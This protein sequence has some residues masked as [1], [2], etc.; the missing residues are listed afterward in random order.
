MILGRPVNKR[1]RC[2]RQK[3]LL[4]RAAY[5]LILIL[6]VTFASACARR[7]ELPEQAQVA[8]DRGDYQTAA[9]KY[10]EFLKVNPHHDQVPTV[11][12]KVANIY[13]YHL[14]QYDRAIQQYIHLIE[15]YPNSAD[16][17]VSRQ[18]LAECYAALSKHREAINEYESLLAA[19]PEG[20]DRRRIRLN[21]ADLYYDLNDLGQALAEYE[22]VI[23]DRV[24]DALAERAWL[25]IAG[26]RFLRD[27]FEEALQAYR[28][29]AEGASEPTIK[30][31]ARYGMIDCY[32][33]TFQY[34]L[35]VKL[36][37]ET[38]ADPK[39]AGYI[40]RRIASMREQQRQR[41]FSNTIESQR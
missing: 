40:E 15:D 5:M 26:I 32:E 27:E 34:D 23:Q 13:Y 9:L 39:N 12:F 16:V 33:R 30:R 37:E 18:R 41:N 29:V 1:E 22:K 25:R 6:S 8:W 24:Y 31:Q 2:D 35:A 7:G 17:A 20:I 14:R 19:A 4:S 11:R 3:F 21:I 10:E 28:T 36:L 38:G